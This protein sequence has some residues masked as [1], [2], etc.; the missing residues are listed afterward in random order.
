MPQTTLVT[1]SAVV[2]LSLLTGCAT[3]GPSLTQSLVAPV[4]LQTEDD[5]EEG[6]LRLETQRVVKSP[7]DFKDYLVIVTDFCE[8]AGNAPVKPIDKQFNG[9]LALAYSFHTIKNCNL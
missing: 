9:L 7:K 1:V 3:T 5:N 6:T 4:I 2:A 8:Q